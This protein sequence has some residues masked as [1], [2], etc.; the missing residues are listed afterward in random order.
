MDVRLRDRDVILAHRDV[1]IENA[2]SGNFEVNLEIG[3][4]PILRGWVSVDAWINGKKI[5]FVNTHLDPTNDEVRE[6]QAQELINNLAGY[7]G[8]LVVVGDINSDAI[9]EEPVYRK[10]IEVGFDDAW[11]EA[12]AK[13]GAE[14]GATCCQDSDLRNEPQ[15]GQLARRIDVIFTR[16]FGDFHFGAVTTGNRPNERTEDP[17]PVVFRSCWGCGW[18]RTELLYSQLHNADG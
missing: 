10:F 1:S 4:V 7:K 2:M 13:I 12:E 6:A 17:I 16:E 5:R 18:R 11:T 14:L 3:D 8:A 9:A 15:V